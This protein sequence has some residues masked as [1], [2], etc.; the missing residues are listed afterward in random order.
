MRN[1]WSFV[2]GTMRLLLRSN[3]LSSA[4]HQAEGP[5]EAK[6]SRLVRRLRA[7]L[8]R[9]IFNVLSASL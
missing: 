3:V 6:H 5:T 2:I 9:D 8:G 1:F 4:A 7:L